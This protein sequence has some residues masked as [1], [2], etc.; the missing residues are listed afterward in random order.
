MDTYAVEIV[1]SSSD[2]ISLDKSSAS[3][4][5]MEK[6]TPSDSRTQPKMQ[7]RITP[8]YSLGKWLEESCFDEHFHNLRI[9]MKEKV[10]A[11]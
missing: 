5:D 2:T 10:V 11:M 7:L 3:E 4:L 8:P 6:G 1:R 9:P